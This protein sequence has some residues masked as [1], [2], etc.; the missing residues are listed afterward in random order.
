MLTSQ[1]QQS[2]SLIVP[3]NFC[4]VQVLTPQL[5]ALHTDITSRAVIV[6]FSII[7]SKFCAVQVLMPQL[8][9]L[10]A[11]ITTLAADTDSERRKREATLREVTELKDRL[12]QVQ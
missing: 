12:Q 11:D 9:A 2:L 10:T 6:F 1:V 7:P 4:A 3:S 5:E 8:E